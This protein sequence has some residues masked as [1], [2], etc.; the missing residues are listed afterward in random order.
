L[1]PSFGMV[2]SETSVIG[3]S[4]TSGAD[5]TTSSDIKNKNQ[6]V[7]KICLAILVPRVN[8]ARLDR[9]TTR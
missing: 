4:P 9:R 1:T 8:I 2:G 5:G 6:Y 7:R 3:T